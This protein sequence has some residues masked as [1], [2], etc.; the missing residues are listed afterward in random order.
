M[1]VRV[2][3]KNSRFQN[4]TKLLLIF[5]M[6]TGIRESFASKKRILNTAQTLKVERGKLK[7]IVKKITLLEKKLERSN[8]KVLKVNRRKQKL[9]GNLFVLRKELLGSMTELAE[10]KKQLNQLI[11]SVAVNTIGEE[12]A[13]AVIAT[14]IL[15]DQLVKDLNKYKLSIEE[16]KRQQTRLKKIEQNIAL[17][18]SREKMLLEAIEGLES[19]KR[20]QAKTYV[21]VKKWIN[22]A[23][24]KIQV[25][26]LKN[27]KRKVASNLKK[28]IGIFDPPIESFISMDYRKKGVTFL[29]N[30]NQPITAGRKGTV[31]HSG[32]LSTYGN[33]IM[34]DHK[35]DIISLC[36]GDFKPRVK[37]GEIVS[38]GQVLGHGEVRSPGKSSKVYFEVRKKN[39]AQETI[40]LLNERILA[41]AVKTSRKS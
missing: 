40:H 8:Q 3:L 13:G 9:E 33:V 7:R 31:I 38:K 17:Y 4:F 41:S 16:T 28:L 6:A 21:K 25:L 36:L 26:K 20:Q 2:V 12:D 19:S 14:K 37:K 15:K 5:F 27:G 22:K 30:E 32:T 1:N 39:K 10:G 18:N 29:F 24:S 34:I 35:N 11:R 23:K